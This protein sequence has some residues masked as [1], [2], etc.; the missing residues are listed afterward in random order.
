MSKHPIYHMPAEWEHHRACIILYPH[1]TGVFRSN[2]SSDCDDK[3]AK[4][5]P[6][7]LEVRNVARAIR[8]FG[9]EDV[10]LFCNTAEEAKDLSMILKEEEQEKSANEQRVVEGKEKEGT[11][12]IHSNQIF[13]KICKSDDSWCRDT[14][15]TFVRKAKT[16]H[17]DTSNN[18]IGLDWNFNAY[19]G[20][21]EGCY[22]PCSND[23]KVAENI[24]HVLSEHYN[25]ETSTS[26]TEK[27]GNNTFTSEKVDLILEGGSFHT[28][29]EGTI[30]TTE[31]CLLNQNRNPNMTQ[32]QIEQILLRYLG[33][34]KVIWLPFGIYNDEDTNGHVDNIATFSK[35]GEIVL[36]WTDNINDAN[37]E[38]CK[39]A[40]T[41]LLN[42]T[43]AQGR[44]ITI[45][46]L[47]LP[48]PLHY[49][50]EEVQTL[51]DGGG[52]DESVQVDS[53]E[54]ESGERLA[55]SYVNY[56]LAN[57]AI[58]L[59]QFGDTL[60]D[61]RAEETIKSIFPSKKIICIYSREI[62]LG[63][64]NIHCITQQL[65]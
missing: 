51:S 9:K 38:R 54:R 47:H 39:A 59:P 40:E 10:F 61:K 41:V 58:I 4:C 21:D 35:P 57:D 5:G 12:E 27:N 55:A 25:N 32:K 3:C 44:K 64:G 63:G 65:P 23:Q 15:P 33:G 50:S 34:S 18:I 43:D 6:A 28:D 26:I 19:G 14:G 8:D 7:R 30:L 56:Y 53:C 29:G 11:S 36:S 62:L 16:D 45:Q 31:E 42:E 37:Y 2:S 60:F 49:T 13:V 1:N 24:I 22:W 20:P 46:K 52:G 17:S 48:R